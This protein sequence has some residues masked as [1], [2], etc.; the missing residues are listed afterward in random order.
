MANPTLDALTAYAGTHEKKLMGQLYKELMLQ[1]EGIMVMPGI[2]GKHKL[3]RLRVG[4]GL[5]PYTGKFASADDQFKY[6]DREIEVERAQRDLEIDPEKYRLTYLAQYQTASAGSN[7][8]KEGQIPFAPYT[9]GEFM[10]ENASEVVDLLYWG[11]G[12]AAFAS[13]NPASTYSVGALVKISLT[14]GGKA[15]DN[16][17]RCKTATSAGESPIT[18]PAKWENVNYLAITKGFRPRITEAISNEGF[19]QIVSTGAITSADAYSQFTA[20]FRGQDEIVKRQGA[21]I[22]CAQNSY[23]KLLDSIET[24]VTKNFELINNIAF[25]PKTDN[26]CR[27]QPVSWMAGSN[28]LLCTPANNFRLGTDQLDD[29]NKLTNIPQHYTLET[30]LSFLIGTQIADLDVLV[31]NDQE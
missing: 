7:A 6:S 1:A 27:I 15:E 17:F 14:I 4:R 2:K 18:H 5:K 12:K 8:N 31:I 29:M 13:F 16:Y 26:K 23:E 24:T 20:V 28:A 19:D 22:Y 11:R 21:V 25:L 10:K 9:W 3:P 30:S